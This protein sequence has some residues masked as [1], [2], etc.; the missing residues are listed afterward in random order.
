MK[1]FFKKS[2][3]L[4]ILVD[5]P[6]GV[7]LSPLEKSL[8]QLKRLFSSASPKGHTAQIVFLPVFMGKYLHGMSIVDYKVTYANHAQFKHKNKTIVRMFTDMDRKLFKLPKNE[9]YKYVIFNL[10]QNVNNLF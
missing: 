7:I 4:A 5:P 10:F 1:K 2:K 9:G 6:F 3:R 8:N